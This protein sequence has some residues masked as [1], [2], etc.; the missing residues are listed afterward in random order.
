MKQETRQLITGEPGPAPPPTR[1]TVAL[2]GAL[3]MTRHPLFWAKDSVSIASC[4]P[5]RLAVWET[6]LSALSRTR[7]GGLEILLHWTQAR[8]KLC[9]N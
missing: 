2:G 7:N 6:F 8:K 1:G 4:G 5:H 9:V 3:L